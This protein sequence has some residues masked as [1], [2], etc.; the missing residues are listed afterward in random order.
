MKILTLIVTYNGMRWLE[1]CLAELS[2]STVNTDVLVVDNCSTDNTVEFITNNYPEIILF[3]Q[4]VNLGFGQANNIG[5]RYALS[6]NY[7]FVLLLNQ[8]AYLQPD[9]LEL[10][11]KESDGMSL[12]TPIHMSGDGK[13]IDYVF[14]KYSLLKADN[15]L[16]DDLLVS[17]VKTAYPIGEV[18]AACWFM[19]IEL[20]KKI[21]GF[22]PLFAHYGEDNNY[23]QRMVYHNCSVIVVPKARVFHDREVHGNM[24]VFN[25]RLI[26]REILLS[27]SNP[28][29]NGVLRIIKSLIGILIKYRATLLKALQA[30]ILVISQWK[31]I[32]KSRKIDKEIGINWL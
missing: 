24:T 12:L 21:G 6:N 4:S 5:L 19:P 23:Y 26:E 28:N 11:L 25:S 7:D 17:S 30:M 13:H 29:V 14:K 20:I 32:S 15:T 8:D 9:A 16:I 10:L 18:C 3:P 31:Q 1:R 27:V 2:A 22:N